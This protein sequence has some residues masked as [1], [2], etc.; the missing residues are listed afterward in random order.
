M[1]LDLLKTLE[2]G[3]FGGT[4]LSQGKVAEGFLILGIVRRPPSC[5]LEASWPPQEAWTGVIRSSVGCH[6]NLFLF[7]AS[8]K[9]GEFSQG[10]TLV[11]GGCEGARHHPPQAPLSSMRLFVSPWLAVQA[12]IM[13]TSPP[14]DNSWPHH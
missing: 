2:K 11:D 14:G 7:P 12:P 1:L 10:L 4:L 5:D 8:D 13:F 3:V 9:H 6:S